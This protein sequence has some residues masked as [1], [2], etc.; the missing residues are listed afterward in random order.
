MCVTVRS[1]VERL[2]ALG[3]MP[4]DSTEPDEELVQDWVAALDGLDHVLTDEEAIALL[5]CFPLDGSEFLELTWH[6]LHAIESAPYGPALLR[7]LDDRSWW[8]ALLR[9]R[10]IRGGIDFPRP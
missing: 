9:Q 6:L 4:E 2:V 1:S 3:R 10:A 7:E 5:P 8:T